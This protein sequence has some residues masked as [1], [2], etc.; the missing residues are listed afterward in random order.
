MV[1]NIRSVLRFFLEPG[2]TPG[3]F[4]LSTMILGAAGNALYD[5]LNDIIPAALAV[6]VIALGVLVLFVLAFA[7]VREFRPR[8][9]TSRIKPMRGL[10]V[11]VS[12][13]ELENIPASEAIKFHYAPDAKEHALDHCWL[14]RTPA[15][16][17]EAD[18]PAKSSWMNA[19]S[20][21][22]KYRGRVK[23]YLK[24][25]EV[26]DP[27]SVSMALAQ[28]Y[29]EARKLKLKENEIVADITGGTKMMSVGMALAGIAAGIDLT[30]LKARQL[31][32][33]GRANPGAGSDPVRVDINYF[34]KETGQE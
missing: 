31:F 32:P 23:M 25:V 20:L 5:S 26:D 18:G 24:N 10:I 29:Q 14:L 22:E 28:A 30:Y 27:E 7:M 2:P 4:V 33:D 34:R 9:V 12:Q 17:K 15:P 19:Q 3:L 21:E 6:L 1:N 8:V 16:L 11:L 13:G